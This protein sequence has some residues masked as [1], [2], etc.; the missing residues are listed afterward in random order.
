MKRAL[1]YLS[2]I[3]YL[4]IVI[5]P[6]F[7]LVQTSLKESKE[8]FTGAS[9]WSLPTKIHWENFSKAW[10]EGHFGSYFG[11]SIKITF[12]SMVLIL[13]CGTMASYVIGHLKHPLGKPIRMYFLAGLMLPMQLALIPLFFLML[14]L[15]LM[16]TY[17]GL[18][19]MYSAGA[20]P[21]TVFVLS[22]FFSSMPNELHDA[23]EIDGCSE[24]QI[25]MKVMLPLARPGLITVA[26]FNFLGVWNEY[27]YALIFITDDK[28]KTLP[29]GLA[30]LAIVKQYDTDFGAL[31]AGTVIVMI[32]TLIVYVL[33]QRHLIKGL[34]AGAIKG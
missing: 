32:P 4:I 26:I 13:V 24:W 15:N 23:A 8:L 10:S 5:Y 16:N 21:F 25:F 20:M 30:N 14:K 18:I 12:G 28:L 33:L 22:G 2:L 9:P 7:W 17:M 3:V 31:F 29:L 19:L 11:N 6:M 34:T 27:L 1:I